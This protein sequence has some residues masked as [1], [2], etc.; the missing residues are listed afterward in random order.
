ML[1]EAENKVTCARMYTQVDV[2]YKVGCRG[3]DIDEFTQHLCETC[4][5]VS[6]LHDT[7]ELDEMIRKIE[8]ERYPMLNSTSSTLPANGQVNREPMAIDPSQ[9]NKRERDSDSDGEGGNGKK[10]AKNVQ[11]DNKLHEPG[12]GVQA[13]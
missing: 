11:H 12:H 7:T 10:S 9:G 3:C 8:E 5:E 6:N 13:D 4:I 2:T 1:E